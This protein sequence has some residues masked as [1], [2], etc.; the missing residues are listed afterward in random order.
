[1]P[2]APVSSRCGRS[3]SRPALSWRLISAPSIVIAGYVPKLEV[4]L[5][6]PGA[7]ARL[8]RIGGLDLG[9]R[10]D[11]HVAGHAV[12]DDGVA[13]L[14]DRRGVRYF[15]D[16]RDAERAGHDGDMARRPA[17]LQHEAAQARAVV[18]EEGRRAHGAGHQDGVVGQRSLGRHHVAADERCSRRLARSSRSCRRSRRY[19]SVW[20]SIRARLSDWTRSTAASAVRP[21]P[22]ASRMRRSQP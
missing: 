7:Q 6:T 21:E 2:V 1:M 15:A 19:G 11:L 9:A 20:R 8:F 18:V 14:H 12:D 4:L 22:T 17:F 16:G 3:T 5:L 10:A 13:L